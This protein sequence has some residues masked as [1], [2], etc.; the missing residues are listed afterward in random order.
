[1]KNKP[2]IRALSASDLKEVV[3]K[4]EE[5]PF[6]ARQLS[7]WIWQKG[8]TDFSQMTNLSLSLRMALKEDYEFYA[9]SLGDKQVS[10]DGTL[11]FAFRTYDNRII[12]SV[13]IPTEDRL[14]VCVSSQ[15]GCSLS[16]SFCATGR[17]KRERNLLACEIFDQ[18]WMVQQEALRVYGSPLTNI[19]Y[20]GMGEPLL[21][22]EQV[23][24]SIEHITS[25]EGLG[26]SPSRITVSTAGIAKMIIR[27]AERFPRVNLALSLHSP[28]D[29]T[30]TAIMPINETNNL[31]SLEKALK[32]YYHIT[33]LPFTFEYVLL[34]G[35]NDRQQ[36]A[37]KLAALCKR[38]PVKVNIIEYNPVEDVPFERPSI[39]DLEAFKTLLQ[40]KGITATVRHSRGADID[41]ACG[42]LANKNS[43]VQP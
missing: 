26:M 17:L 38:L 8:A 29:M 10:A 31:E 27:M 12:E 2:N 40:K 28:D 4:Y 19:V 1:M 6:R 5:K 25:S 33:G 23:A 22:F 15:V 43:A 41:A 35:Q 36:D 11:K 16:C 42:Q 32:Y 39:Q 24:E 9:L 37:L 18:V 13:L 34:A 20:M 30:R 21:N 7:E 3:V 14:T